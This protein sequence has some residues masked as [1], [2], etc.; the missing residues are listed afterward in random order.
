[1]LN[2]NAVSQQHSNL[3]PCRIAPAPSHTAGYVVRVNSVHKRVGQNDT[4]GAQIFS[5]RKF[6]PDAACRPSAFAMSIPGY[7]CFDDAL[8]G[9]TV[10]S[11]PKERVAR[12]G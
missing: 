12:C 7:N 9:I 10:L 3:Q 8:R 11:H 1:M 5:R 4:N 2:T 6:A